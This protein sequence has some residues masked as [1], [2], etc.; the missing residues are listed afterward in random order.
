MDRKRQRE[1]YEEG[2]LKKLLTKHLGEFRTS[3]KKLENSAIFIVILYPSKYWWIFMSSNNKH[4]YWVLTMWKTLCRA[5]YSFQVNNSSQLLLPSFYKRETE[6]LSIYQNIQWVGM[7]NLKFR[8]TQALTHHGSSPL[9]PR[10]FCNQDV[11]TRVDSEPADKAFSHLPSFPS[12]GHGKTEKRDGRSSQE[13]PCA[14]W[15]QGP[16]CEADGTQTLIQDSHCPVLQ[17]WHFIWIY[18]FILFK[19][20]LCSQIENQSTQTET[21]SRDVLSPSEGGGRGKSA[22]LLI[23][24]KT[25]KKRRVIR[26]LRCLHVSAC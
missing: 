23:A 15:P 9:C 5:P 10:C 21:L 22:I 2:I 7:L 8:P 19:T 13:Q 18:L 3:R 26:K 16:E 14:P 11:Q 6:A 17:F 4:I 1:D 20:Q 12:Q 25:N 24:R